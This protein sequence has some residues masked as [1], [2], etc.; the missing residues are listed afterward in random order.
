MLHKSFM[1][2]HQDPSSEPLETIKTVFA[3]SKIQKLW[4]NFQ[5]Y[6]GA[7]QERIDILR[8]QARETPKEDGGDKV[9]PT[10]LKKWTG[11]KTANQ[12]VGNYAEKM[13]CAFPSD[14]INTYERQSKIFPTFLKMKISAAATSITKLLVFEIS[15][16]KSWDVEWEQ[17]AAALAGIYLTRARLL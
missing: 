14:R 6:Q 3:E 7:F 9:M 13:S 4:I 5:V 17:P 8:T 1:A 12:P 15:Y 10:L 2:L 11:G 16:L